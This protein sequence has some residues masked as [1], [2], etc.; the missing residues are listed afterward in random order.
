MV[1]DI[2]SATIVAEERSK[3]A[4]VGLIARSLKYDFVHRTDSEA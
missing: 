4:R 1:C 3:S 2:A